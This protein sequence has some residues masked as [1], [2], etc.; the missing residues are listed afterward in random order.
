MLFL[1]GPS[2][3]D[4]RIP[5][6]SNSA[7][8]SSRLCLVVGAHF[9]KHLFQGTLLQRILERHLPPRGKIQ[10]TPFQAASKWLLQAHFASPENGLATSFPCR[11][12]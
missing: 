9:D 1:G 5:V 7:G 4:R 11:T 2:T 10:F 3:L 12:A 6:S 8:N